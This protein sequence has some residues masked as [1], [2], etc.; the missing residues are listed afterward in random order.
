MWFKTLRLYPQNY[1]T[2]KTTVRNSTSKTVVYGKSYLS[3]G[4]PFSSCIVYQSKDDNLNEERKFNSPFVYNNRVE[5]CGRKSDGEEK[6]L[7]P[8]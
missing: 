6:G 7:G 3:L 4:N 5:E 8:R 1:G 2:F